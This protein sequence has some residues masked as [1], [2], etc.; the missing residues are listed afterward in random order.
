[1][2]SLKVLNI[3]SVLWVTVCCHCIYPDVSWCVTH[4]DTTCS[5][6]DK[7]WG[8]F[9]G[10]HML[11]CIYAQNQSK[12]IS[13]FS[14]ILF[15]Y[16]FHF[17]VRTLFQFFSNFSLFFLPFYSLQKPVILTQHCSFLL[18]FKCPHSHC[19]VC[20]RYFTKSLRATV[21]MQMVY[22]TVVRGNS[23]WVCDKG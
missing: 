5:Y 4:N 18:L 13:V 17:T 6:H 3:D 22:S 21:F 23:N 15:L 9:V 16:Y 14:L 7:S 12:Y 20:L 2:N 11:I 1:M 19:E 10:A 8:V